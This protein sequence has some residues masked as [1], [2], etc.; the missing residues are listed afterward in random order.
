M[1]RGVTLLEMLLALALVIAL[2]AIA[3]PAMLE[4]S[5][6]EKLSD[7]AEAIEE[8]LLLARG[9]AMVEGVSVE[10]RF[11]PQTSRMVVS[12]VAEAPEREPARA[13]EAG[14]DESLP[15]VTRSWAQLDVDPEITISNEPPE[16][17]AEGGLAPREPDPFS[18]TSLS[19]AEP[20]EHALA[21]DSPEWITCAMYLA[22]GSA[23][24][25]ESIWLS[26]EV[27]RAM[28]ID[29]GR[30]TGIPTIDRDPT[31][32]VEPAEESEESEQEE[33][34]DRA[35]EPPAEQSDA[36]RLEATPAETSLEDDA[37]SPDADDD[38]QGS[39]DNDSDDE[40]VDSDEDES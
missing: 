19:Y 36:P 6:H 12:K 7:S 13:L 3:L 18:V 14:Q 26:T 27:G 30:W 2:G 34:E 24:V 38:T 31:L 4:T 8:Q 23:P 16:Q 1:R 37:E 9:H 40:E 22:D 17:R 29:I 21:D 10:V 20:A 33:T 11:N 15:I 39:D 32:E 35:T 28:R 25:A 5:E